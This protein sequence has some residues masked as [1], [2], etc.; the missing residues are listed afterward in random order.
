MH[1]FKNVFLACFWVDGS[2]G[3]DGRM[4]KSRVIFC[5]LCACM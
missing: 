2:I 3:I 5:T 4:G 1:I